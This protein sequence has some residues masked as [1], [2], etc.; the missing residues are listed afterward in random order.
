MRALV[1]SGGGSKGAYAGGIAEYLIREQGRKYDIFAGTSTGSLLVPLLAAGEID[2]IKQMYCNVR[3]G[4][5][6][7]VCPFTFKK[8]DGRY[9][10]RF[11]HLG[12]LRQ[13]I[14]GRKTFGESR[15]LRKL[16]RQTLT[17]EIFARL[18]SDP[19]YVIVTVANLSRDIVEY[20][21]L[22]DYDYDAFCDWIW[23]SANLVPFMS[24]VT[25]HGDE[26][27][28]GGF[29][30]P[31]PIQEAINLGAREIDVIKLIPRHRPARNVPSRNAFNLLMKG[32][33]FM[34]H[35]LAQDDVSM[36]LLESRYTDIKI[37]LIHTE[38]ILT[39][40]SVIFDPEQMRSWW[41]EGWE[42]AERQ[43][44]EDGA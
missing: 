8:V 26:Y 12:I 16:I 41:Q 25:K 29:G 30:N 35:Q 13:F 19:A 37:N 36:S 2:R 6:F 40:N 38:R 27:A 9:K 18:K 23:V 44:G 4:D 42:Y 31:V 14:L 7:S 43:F 10:T 34:L 24:L 39:D 22:R 32:F 3:Q 17:P 21:Y 28:D 33:N 11:N 5:I 1:I 20:K 15:N